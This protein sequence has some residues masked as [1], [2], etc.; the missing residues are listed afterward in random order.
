MTRQIIIIFVFIACLL[1]AV[2]TYWPKKTETKQV[3]KPPAATTIITEESQAKQITELEVSAP[4]AE[5]KLVD[6]FSLRLPVRKKA[7]PT[8]NANPPAT[9]QVATPQLEGIWVDSGMRVAFISGQSL[10]VGDTIMGWR[11]AAIYSS[12]V[13]LQRGSETKTLKLEAK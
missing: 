13:V 9:I 10:S 5:V 1:F 12:Q 6:P 3:I 8:D 11:V 4:S 2:Y 7:T